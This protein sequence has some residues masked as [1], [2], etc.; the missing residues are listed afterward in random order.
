[1]KENNSGLLRRW[2]RSSLSIVVALAL[3]CVVVLTASTAMLC[4][5]AQRQELRTELYA[6]QQL[7]KSGSLTPEEALRSYNVMENHW[8]QLFDLHG[9][10]ILTVGAENGVP[11]AQSDVRNAIKTG[12]IKWTMGHNAAAHGRVM[13]M[14]VP[15]MDESG[16][17]LGILRGVVR[18]NETDHA[19]LLLTG[20]IVLVAAGLMVILY[21]IQRFYLRSVFVPITEITTTA[22]RIA[23]GSYGVQISRRYDD[24][25]GELADTINDMSNKISQNEKMQSEFMSRVS[26]ELRTPLTAIGGWSE[27]LLSGGGSVD[28]AEA[29]RGLSIILRETRRLTGMVEDLLEFTRM[30]DGRF[31]LNV[32]PADLRAEFEDTVFMYGSRLQREGI[33]LEYLENDEDIPE[34][35]CDKERMRQVFLNILDNAVKHGGEGGKITAEMRREDDEVVIRIR[36]FGCGIPAEELPLVKKKFYKGSSKARGSGIGL[37]VC[38]EIVSMHNGTLTLENA[39]GGGTLVTIR[40]PIA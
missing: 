14:A 29:Q 36:D 31:T 15:V 18:L 4:Y 17:V 16:T 34:I 5:S 2:V 21:I 12:E 20:A 28:T 7:C 30:Q 6:L 39:P 3:V 33:E 27:T 19:V 11:E 37:A 24:E 32:A 26:H 25:I 10:P 8:M 9:E 35:P 23:A 38:E 13:A 22:K 40:L 1:M